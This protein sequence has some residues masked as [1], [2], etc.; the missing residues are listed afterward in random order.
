[1]WGILFGRPFA[2]DR[3]VDDLP[4]PAVDPDLQV[5]DLLGAD[6]REHGYDLRRLIR[7]IAATQA[8]RLSSREPSGGE[9]AHPPQDQEAVEQAGE[10][11]LAENSWGVFPVVRLR[12]EQVIGAMLQATNLKT[13]DQNSHLLVRTLRLVRE[14]D[15]VNEYGDPGVEELQARPMTIPQAL[16][17][18]NGQLSRELTEPNPFLSGGR[19]LGAASSRERVIEVAFLVCLTRRPTPDEL[20]Y[21]G[22]QWDWEK[23]RGAAMQDLLWTLFNS[24]EF[25]WNH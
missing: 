13:I 23:D 19:I 2:A 6:F 12:P 10:Q 14:G 25:N 7:V 8:F 3:P 9:A 18:M 21:F 1:M 5:L 22:S 4:D 15:F 24:P 20:A 16:L 11:S 17:S